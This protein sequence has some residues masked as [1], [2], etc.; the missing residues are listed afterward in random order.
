MLLL[1]LPTK[2]MKCAKNSKGRAIYPEKK[3]NKNY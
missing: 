2:I 1:P 3:I